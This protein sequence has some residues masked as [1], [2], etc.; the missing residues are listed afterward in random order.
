MFHGKRTRFLIAFSIGIVA[1]G[2]LVGVSFRGS[3]VYYLTVGEFFDF[4]GTRPEP[5]RVNGR[6]APGT[7][8]KQSGTLGVQFAITD[9][10]RF[11]PVYYGREVPDTFVDGAEVV[12]EGDLDD[13]GTFQAHMLLAKCPSKYESQDPAEAPH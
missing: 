9:G 13:R 2:L 6:V 5:V 1:V 10:D 7:I 3:M 8:R 12:V 4:P 11:L